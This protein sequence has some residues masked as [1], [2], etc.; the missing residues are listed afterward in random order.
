L[1]LGLEK[2][3]EEEPFFVLLT[4]FFG[5][6]YIYSKMHVGYLKPDWT[7]L[8]IS[9]LL[10]LGGYASGYDACD[11]KKPT[12]TIEA[13]ISL[14]QLFPHSGEDSP[15]NR[16]RSIMNNQIRSQADLLD[17]PRGQSTDAQ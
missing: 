12:R 14:C 4:N 15:I 3:L 9:L 16:C 17:D 6:P 5:H 13:G 2:L 10:E 8:T 1:N 7:L 11:P